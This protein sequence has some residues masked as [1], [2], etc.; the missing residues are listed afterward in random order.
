M[1][2]LVTL[3]KREYIMKFAVCL[4]GRDETQTVGAS[5]IVCLGLLC[6]HDGVIVEKCSIN[7][8]TG[9][10]M[11]LGAYCHII[12]NDAARM[13]EVRTALSWYAT[14]PLG[15]GGAI[16]RHMLHVRAL[17]REIAHTLAEGHAIVFHEDTAENETK[18]LS[19]IK[20]TRQRKQSKSNSARKKAVRDKRPPKVG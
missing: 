19:P 6:A 20:R 15:M 16:G 2:F 5:N 12:L 3:K 7:P 9:G 4:L 8:R 18:K 14:T 17:G 10:R 11:L 1:A 13:K